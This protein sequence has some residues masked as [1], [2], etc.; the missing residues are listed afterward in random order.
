MRR[1]CDHMALYFM[2]EQTY[3]VIISIVDI[4]G[5]M[6]V[7]FTKRRIE[8][9]TETYTKRRQGAFDLAVVGA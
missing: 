9:Q 6:A 1:A 7:I 2:L 8:K 5:H 4:N 3:P